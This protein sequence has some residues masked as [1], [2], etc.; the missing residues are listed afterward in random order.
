MSGYTSVGWVKGQRPWTY[1]GLVQ[2]DGGLVAAHQQIDTNTTNVSALFAGNISKVPDV[3]TLTGI[4]GS[5][6]GEVKQ[7]LGYYTPGDS[8]PRLMIR[9]A[10]SK[11]V[12]TGDCLSCAAGGTARWEQIYDEPL[13]YNVLH[14]GAKGAGTTGAT[15]D[16]NAVSSILTTY[17]LAGTLYFPASTDT[18]S[19][20]YFLVG[21]Y[22]LKMHS[23]IGAGTTLVDIQHTGNNILFSS[24]H[25]HYSAWRRFRG[26]R[27]FLEGGASSKGLQLGNQYMAQL[28]DVYIRSLAKNAAK[29]IELLNYDA[30]FSNPDSSGF[31][32]GTR[33]NNVQIRDCMKCLSFV[34]TDGTHGTDSFSDTRLQHVLLAPTTNNQVGL[35]VGTEGGSGNNVT[36]YSCSLD[37]KIQQGDPGAMT[38]KAIDIGPA[39]RVMQSRVN[40]LVENASSTSPALTMAANSFL[41]GTGRVEVL[42]QYD[43]PAVSNINSSARFALDRGNS[44]PVQATTTSGTIN[45]STAFVGAD[46][47]KVPEKVVPVNPGGVRTDVRMQAG[48]YDGHE[49]KIIN[50]ST[51]TIGFSTVE[52]TSLVAG[53]SA[54]T[55][56]VLGAARSM[57]L[58]WDANY[59]SAGVGRWCVNVG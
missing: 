8:P 47:S 43:I 41:E 38:T 31:V 48:A 18:V 9:T 51:N 15:A 29:G 36:L 59:V 45:V 30:A 2:M 34:R 54:G 4:T 7:L 52:S 1:E 58:V 37:L 50:R 14:W 40:V 39:S 17:P 20:T 28:D 33:M 53:S 35:D 32:E 42:T 13:H 44:M 27:L 56:P 11:T 22:T 12:N 16:N 19:G 10:S 6:V 24:M 57:T 23:I 5:S 49:V 26:F 55:P 46:G 25:I 21:P 3:D